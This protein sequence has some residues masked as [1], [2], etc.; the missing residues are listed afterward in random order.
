MNILV[1]KMTERVKMRYRKKTDE[2]F[3]PGERLWVYAAYFD[4]LKVKYLLVKY[5]YR[6]F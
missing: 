5:D 1:I 4:D 3:A 6:I 2:T